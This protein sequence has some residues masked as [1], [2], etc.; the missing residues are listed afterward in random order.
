VNIFSVKRK[1]DLKLILLLLLS[2]AFCSNAVNLDQ[3]TSDFVLDTSSLIK[4]I[5]NPRLNFKPKTSNQ[6]LNGAP[7]LLG[8]DLD[9]ELFTGDSSQCS[10]SCKEPENFLYQTGKSYIYKFE[11][12]SKILNQKSNEGPEFLIKGTAK[13]NVYKPCEY[14]L[15]LDSIEIKGVKEEAKYARLL[16]QHVLPF[17]FDDGLIESI[18]P[19]AGE[20]TWVLN[21]KRALLSSLQVSIENIGGKRIVTETDIVGTCP[22]TY[23]VT[24][25]SYTEGTRVKKVKD[26]AACSSRSHF[27]LPIFGASFTAGSSELRSSRFP[28]EQSDYQ[29]EQVLGQDGLIHKAICYEHSS[30]FYLSALS[31]NY[32]KRLSTV[33]L[34]L[35]SRVER[36]VSKPPTGSTRNAKLIF[37][38]VPANK[39]E[40]LSKDKLKQILYN[41]CLSVSDELK[42]QSTKTFFDLVLALQSTVA[43]EDLKALWDEIKAAGGVNTCK[44]LKVKHLFL[45]AIVMSANSAP[46]KLIANQLIDAKDISAEKLD[47]MFTLFALKSNIDEK[48]LAETLPLFSR[49]DLSRQTLLGVSAALQ[50]YALKNGDTF[51]TD[52]RSQIGDIIA[53]PIADSCELLDGKRASDYIVRIKALA[54]IRS[55]S[56]ASLAKVLG[57]AT[58][59]SSVKSSVKLAAVDALGKLGSCSPSIRTILK[60]LLTSSVCDEIRITAFKGYMKCAS[61]EDF[62][63]ILGLLKTLESSNLGSYIEAYLKNLETT[64]NPEKELLKYRLNDKLYKLDRFPR[65]IR[66]YSS[67]FEYS[68]H[69]SVLNLGYNVELD[70]IFTRKSFLPSSL[71]L[72]VTLPAADRSF[73][74]LEIGLRQRGLDAKLDDLFGPGG[75]FSVNELQDILDDLLRLLRGDGLKTKNKSRLARSIGADGWDLGKMKLI[76]DKM[77]PLFEKMEEGS[78]YINF[79]GKTLLYLDSEDF[80]DDKSRLSSNIGG[81]RSNSARSRL[82][83]TERVYSFGSILNDFFRS[84]N[85][86]GLVSNDIAYRTSSVSGISNEVFL[87]AT[88]VATYHVLNG[89]ETRRVRRSVFGDLIN[90][91]NSRRNSYTPTNEE[92]VKLFTL[93]PN[94]YLNTSV[95]WLLSLGSNEDK[96][97]AGINSRGS[98][99]SNVGLSGELNYRENK[100]YALKVQLAKPKSDLLR[101]KT[102]NYKIHGHGL[103]ELIQGES[104]QLKENCDRRALHKNFGLT[105]C[106]SVQLPEMLLKKPINLLHG[107]IELGVSLLVSDPKLQGYKFIFDYPRERSN[108]RVYHFALEALGLRN[109]K[110]EIAYV[111]HSERTLLNNHYLQLNAPDLEIEANGTLKYESGDKSLRLTTKINRELYLLELGL[112][113]RSA[114]EITEYKPKILLEFPTRKLVDIDGSLSVLGGEKPVIKAELYS[115]KEGIKSRL[116]K[117]E[118]SREGVL[119]IRRA[120]LLRFRRSADSF[121]SA[122]NLQLGNQKQKRYVNIVALV[123]KTTFLSLDFTADYKSLQMTKA[124]KLELHTKFYD[125]GARGLIQV[126]TVG[127]LISSEYPQYNGHLDQKF[128]Y[129]P[130]EHLENELTIRWKGKMDDKRKKIY[131]LQTSKMAGNSKSEH[132]VRYYVGPLNINHEHS[133]NGEYN[134]GSKPKIS[135]IYVR[136]DLNK[137]NEELNRALI[138]YELLST[139]PKKVAIELY[140]KCPRGE[141]SYKDEII[142]ESPNQYRGK[143][144]FKQNLVGQAQKGFTVDSIY[145]RSADKK[146]VDFGVDVTTIPSNKKLADVKYISDRTKPTGKYYGILNYAGQRLYTHDAAIG[147][148]SAKI[149]LIITNLIN[150]ALNGDAKDSEL[151]IKS[152]KYQFENRA[153]ILLSGSDKVI[154]NNFTKNGA[155]KFE[156]KLST[157]G[158]STYN[159]Y[160]NT[161]GVDTLFKHEY[162]NQGEFNTRLSVNNGPFLNHETTL[163]VKIGQV[164]FLTNTIDPEGSKFNGLLDLDINSPRIKVEMSGKRFKYELLGLKP[165]EYSYESKSK[166]TIDGIVKRDLSSSYNRRTH[167]FLYNVKTDK[168]NLELEIRPKNADSLPVLKLIYNYPKYGFEHKTLLLVKPGYELININSETKQKSTLIASLTARREVVQG[169]K[170]IVG[171]LNIQI[172]QVWSLNLDTERD[173]DNN[174]GKLLLSY[175][176]PNDECTHNTEILFDRSMFRI[177]SKTMHESH[178]VFLVD[179]KLTSGESSKIEFVSKLLN[180]KIVLE[181]IGNLKKFSIEITSQELDFE[182]IT[183]QVTYEALGNKRNVNLDLNVG[184]IGKYTAKSILELNQDNLVLSYIASAPQMK[185]ESNYKFD[186]SYSLLQPQAIKMRHKKQDT[187]SQWI[188]KTDL[189]NGLNGEHEILINNEQVLK[190]VF[191]GTRSGDFSLVNSPKGSYKGT[192]ELKYGSV[193]D[194][195]M[196]YDHERS[197]SQLNGLFGLS[198]KDDQYRLESKYEIKKDPEDQGLLDGLDIDYNLSYKRNID[199]YKLHY[200]YE[201]GDIYTSVLSVLKYQEDRIVK[202]Y[203]QQSLVYTPLPRNEKKIE[204]DLIF[205]SN[206]LAYTFEQTDIRYKLD[207]SYNGKEIVNYRSTPFV[208]RRYDRRNK[209]D[210]LGL[211]DK[212]NM[213]TSLNIFGRHIKLSTDRSGATKKGLFLICESKSTPIE[214]CLSLETTSFKNENG[215]NLNGQIVGL[216]NDLRTTFEYNHLHQ[217]SKHSRKLLLFINNRRYGLENLHEMGNKLSSH[218]IKYYLPERVLA[219]RCETIKKP[220]LDSQGYAIKE[221]SFDLWSDFERKPDSKLTLTYNIKSKSEDRSS[222]KYHEYTL[223]HPVWTRVKTLKY[224]SNYELI[225]D[226]IKSELKIDLDLLNEPNSKLIYSRLYEVKGSKDIKIKWNLSSEDKLVDLNYEFSKLKTADEDK[227]T[228]SSNIKLTDGSTVKLFDL[229]YNLK[230]ILNAQNSGY[231]MTFEGRNFFGLWPLISLSEEYLLATDGKKANY[232]SDGQFYENGEKYRALVEIQN[233]L[234]ESFCAKADLFKLSNPSKKNTISTCY[235]SKALDKEEAF[236]LYLK[237]ELEQTNGQLLVNRLGSYGS[238]YLVKTRWNPEAV[239]VGLIQVAEFISEVTKDFQKRSEKIKLEASRQQRQLY[240][241]LED[242]VL[243]PF[244]RHASRVIRELSEEM[245]PELDQLRKIQLP[246][247]GSKIRYYLA[248]ATHGRRRLSNIVKRSVDDVNAHHRSNLG[249]YTKMGTNLYNL[250]ENVYEIK[251]ITYNPDDGEVDFQI[252]L[253]D[254][255]PRNELAKSS[256]DKDDD[257]DDDLDLIDYISQIRSYLKLGFLPPF[258]AQAMILFG[259]QYLTFDGEV[260]NFDGSSSCSYLLARDFKDDR[261]SIVA[262]YQGGQLD[263]KTNRPSYS[264]LVVLDDEETVELFPSSLTV[265]KNGKPAQFPLYLNDSQTIVAAKQ[266]YIVLKSLKNGLKIKCYSHQ[267]ICAISVSGY[268]FG[269]IGG[270]LGRYNYEKYDDL[271]LDDK[272]RVDNKASQFQIKASCSGGGSSAERRVDQDPALDD[273]L[274]DLFLNPKSPL[275]DAYT[276]VDVSPF[277]TIGKREASLVKGDRAQILELECA[278]ASAYLIRSYA[279]GVPLRLPSRC[280]AS[281]DLP[282]EPSKLS[283]GNSLS[284]LEMP[285]YREVDYIFVVDNRECNRPVVAQLSTLGRLIEQELKG[286]RAQ[287]KFGLVTY[288]GPVKSLNK[289]FYRPIGGKLL[290][291]SEELNS[292]SEELGF[293]Q[294]SSNNAEQQQLNASPLDALK[295][296]ASYPFRPRAS[297]NIVLIPCGACPKYDLIGYL[298]LK[299]A[300]RAQ[301]IIL[302]TLSTDISSSNDEY[303]IYGFNKTTALTSN[304]NVDGQMAKKSLNYRSDVCTSLSLSLRGS[305]YSVQPLLS[306][307][308]RFVKLFAKSLAH[309]STASLSSCINCE[310]RVVRGFFKPRTFCKPCN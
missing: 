309:Q 174:K 247:L 255:T 118:Y 147:P 262:N 100:P 277:I 5:N 207:V 141:R 32:Y 94:F 236:S 186:I 78:I 139:S 279:H 63:F 31:D 175:K 169:G 212:L 302:H 176:T 202:K 172:P 45:D 135:F 173:S 242:I 50:N 226:L 74:I 204:G 292:A 205:M 220:L 55:L 6:L 218:Y 286:S 149:E 37:D 101:L 216:G 234:E 133:L 49:K 52:I 154:G 92:E 307:D 238:K 296:A 134:L 199:L 231:R 126:Q 102:S 193:N 217:S 183:G 130:N 53:S 57:C 260:Y 297:K 27:S 152:D 182:K 30:L 110:F 155:K 266:E 159:A 163:S 83:N 98:L 165:N 87:D 88:L 97:V 181:P 2:T 223:S 20:E 294:T 44:S 8:T 16:T 201:S 278:L 73:N 93:Y 142:E 119:D 203:L 3:L 136:K 89:Q 117:G 288:P 75:Y 303:T 248:R 209:R 40:L 59:G 196:E 68:R 184:S 227:I 210:T 120:P 258:K 65:D 270:L 11:T 109:K 228:S 107:P 99:H 41:L 29:C 86:L 95:S 164:N 171:K 195:K 179:G 123:Q 232:I 33:D 91:L 116:L 151:V 299:S 295:M 36:L 281:C 132:L 215:Y 284:T 304:D 66:K 166:L 156:L 157:Q 114:G 128:L 1:M 131:I 56:E 15:K 289:P 280:L 185:Y 121:K 12:S 108:K 22:T 197:A 51:T 168:F 239:G 112:N 276:V 113:E 111:L 261:F 230:S 7:E 290:F 9:Q 246:D 189:R 229:I 222:I 235:N 233:G 264:L 61:S 192:V 170:T 115:N 34:E 291:T 273:N 274:A 106:T 249:F 221:G 84:E 251:V 225:N 244:A 38:I 158:S 76:E 240:D 180:G 140:F 18:C 24:S 70:S 19:V 243:R 58:G 129:K 25:K 237:D 190:L 219:S 48:T 150:I 298:R 54:N 301:D 178:I 23:V 103:E 267:D 4:G 198:Y 256:S 245:K 43:Y 79:D 310:C 259:R 250:L 162:L 285:A 17:S 42:P 104:P 188:L 263:P 308:K 167:E 96:S 72:N 153:V 69:L 46:L 127:E 206:K 60:Q 143:S 64:S 145:K 306:A 122:L 10:K 211:S 146:L 194:W 241:P 67:N 268:Y 105:L 85:G 252:N 187:E 272:Q 13:I 254:Q 21:I 82:L 26:L 35:V 81:L 300:L 191:K 253:Y 275:A 28:L 137:P 213:D 265:K 71:V 271:F 287:A 47:F 305:I 80:L 282:F 214:D 208:V 77:K 161:L 124:Q 177:N 293:D 200:S 148:S 125:K 14:G 257:D 224:Y 62:D 144:V 269:K 39:Q 138:K 90:T 160:L 283:V